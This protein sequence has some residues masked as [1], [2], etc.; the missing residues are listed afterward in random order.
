MKYENANSDANYRNFQ[1]D[2]IIGHVNFHG[3]ERVIQKLTSVN[4]SHRRPKIV[5]SS[6][7]ARLTYHSIY[8]NSEHVVYIN[9]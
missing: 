2:L 9:V 6:Y 4:D 8:A 7:L 5:R 3:K 1:L